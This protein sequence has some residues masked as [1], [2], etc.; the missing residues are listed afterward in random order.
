MVFVITQ[1]R[2]SGGPLFEEQRTEI[3]IHV[4]NSGTSCLI[5]DVV[6]ISD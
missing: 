1:G 2:L 4:P 6:M 3:R 5:N